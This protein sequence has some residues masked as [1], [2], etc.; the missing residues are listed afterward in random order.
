MIELFLRGFVLC[1]LTA[2]ALGLLH[3]TAA[4][5]RHLVCVLALVALP[6]LP[7][8]QRLM[9]TLRLLPAQRG[10]TPTRATLPPLQAGR[11]ADLRGKSE[12]PAVPQ[13]LQEPLLGTKPSPLISA[14]SATTAR[15]LAT[16]LLWAMIWGGGAATLLIRLLIALWRLRRLEAGSHPAMVGN[17]SI[18]VSEQIRTPLTW[19]VR[20]SV[21]LL[22]AALLSGEG[23]VC[24]SA[25]RHE[26][27][28]LARWDWIWNLLT[29]I[30]CA[31]CWFQPGAWWLRRRMRL[32]SERA[33][34]DRV[35]LS[36]VAGPDYAAH[37]LQILHSVRT[38]E[39][40]PAMAQSR[41]GM[42]E[43]MRHIL[44]GATPRHAPTKWLAVS[45]LFALALLS[46]S[47]LRV[48]A[49]AAQ[50]KLP[51]EKT[52]P[53]S[54]GARSQPPAAA[55]ATTRRGDAAV[56]VAVPSPEPADIA[57]GPGRD[58]QAGVR[59]RLWA[60][61]QHAARFVFDIYLRN[62]T[63]HTLN[64]T[65][66]SFV[67]LSVP[68]DSSY[69]TEIQS[70]LIYCSPHLQ[71]ST[72]KPLDIGFKLGSEESQYAV[73]PGQIVYV[74]HWMLRTMDRQAK[75]SR[76]ANDT[77]VAFVEP[78]K[79]RMDC[80]LSASWESK[81]GRRTKLRTGQVTFDVTGADVAA[82]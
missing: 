29:E 73:G 52:P 4:A 45:A 27:A 74:S 26:Q 35:L 41:R 60:T 72:G 48:S 16:P 69:S 43:R 13:R 61:G 53:V 76:S 81:G 3:R 54:G 21:I 55:S 47:A 31:F 58:V 40:A 37:L 20:R 56:S 66:P 10:A 7:W 14:E 33:C 80:T 82:E 78:G 25:L 36:G 59:V 51:T 68:T 18:L 57:W 6:L 65:C 64:V 38:N 11:L 34:D 46:L 28:H 30:V 49:R 63:K 9:P 71:D 75:A 22:P 8:V 15:S 2:L 32:E 19:G 77:Q 12:S 44:D 39:V 62:R 50:E 23:S 24:E 70:D 1:L 79:H 17:V 42:E 5:H 67:G